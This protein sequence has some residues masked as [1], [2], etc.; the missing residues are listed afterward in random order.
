ML[1][2][3]KSI[4]LP[5]A[6]WDLCHQLHQ[7]GYQSYIVGGAIRD[8]LRSQIP[9]DWDI[10]TDALP[11]EVEQLFQRT[12]PTG[13]TFG[14]IT[15][16]QGD[17]L[18]EITTMRQDANYSDG[19]RPDQVIYTNDIVLD[20]KRRDFTINAIAYDPISQNYVDPHRGIKDIRKR[21]LRTVGLAK[22]RFN[23]DALRMLRLVRFYATLGFKPDPAAIAGLEPSLLKNV[24]W[25]RI[26]EEFR[27]LILGN[28]IVAALQ[29]L[30]TSGMLEY[31]LPEL[32]KGASVYQGNRHQFDV[33]GHQIQT[34]QAI[35]PIL[36]LRLAALLHDIGKP[37]TVFEDDGGIHF[38][39]HD[40]LGAELARTCLRRMCCSKAL[41]KRVSNLI[42]YHMFPIHPHST[43]RAIRRFIAKVGEENILDLIELRKADVLA[44]KHNPTQVWQYYQQMQ[45]RIEEVLAVEHGFSI[46]DLA[47]NGQ[48]LLEHFGL[49]PSPLIGEILNYLLAE[50][51]DDPLINQTEALLDKT[52]V[53]LGKQNK[54]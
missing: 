48:D 13:K 34:A 30:Y 3:P 4:P 8:V 22:D 54:E 31:I 9:L 28:E 10:T 49:S 41:I 7:H 39:T 42:E 38:Y 2:R 25:E 16:R 26:G 19:R 52:R 17:Y 47:I 36:H 18:V 6:I 29:L 5:Q 43:D 11:V 45:T 44:M 37:E 27:K 53:Y 35:Q 21:R 46:T 20:L 51:I 33:L 15:V 23:E 24:A 12:I 40:T 1:I 32:A 14:T 50:V